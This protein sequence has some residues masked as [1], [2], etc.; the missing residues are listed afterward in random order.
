MSNAENKINKIE[1]QIKKLKEKKKKEEQKLRNNVGKYLLEKWDIDNEEIALMAIDYLE[2][3]A[4][5]FLVSM[6]TTEDQINNKTN[7]DSLNNVPVNN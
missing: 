4:K 5:E 6:S 7:A 3:Q 1:E 2:K